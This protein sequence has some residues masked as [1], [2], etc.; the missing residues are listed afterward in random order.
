MN[1]PPSHVNIYA[2]RPPPK[3]N[4]AW[5]ILAGLALVLIICCVGGVIAGGL[6]YYYYASNNAAIPQLLT[7]SILTSPVIEAPPT[8]PP[9]PTEAIPPTEIPATLP[10]PTISPTL[11]PTPNVNVNNVSFTY[12]LGIAQTVNAETILAAFSDQPD[13]MPGEVYPQHIKFTFNG[14]PLSGTFH[15]PHILVYPAK[16]Y[17]EKDPSAASVIN[18]LTQFL[19]QKPVNPERIPFLPLWNAGQMFHSNIKYLSFKNGNG[20]R[21]LTMYAQA[22]YP[23]NN[24]SLFYTFQGLT[25]DGAYYIAAVMPVSHPS[26]PATGDEIPG[27]DLNTFVDNFNTY[28]METAASLEAQAAN[29]FTPNLALLDAMFETFSV[30]P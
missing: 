25:N 8:N 5:W 22:F 12:P 11:E 7:T 30:N 24:N 20:V 14:Y 27:G 15:S 26:L 28:K 16:E 29:S 18:D 4:T 17:A 23:I 9:P 1:T 13:L 10:P 21:F 2:T 3:R 6:Y 19:V